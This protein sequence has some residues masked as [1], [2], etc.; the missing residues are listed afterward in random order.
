MY[1][2]T[3]EYVL[4][5]F[6]HQN[7]FSSHLHSQINQKASPKSV[8]NEVCPFLNTESHIWEKGSTVINQA[9]ALSKHVYLF[10]NNCHLANTITCVLNTNLATYLLMKGVCGK[11]CCSCQL[12]WWVSFKIP[13]NCGCKCVICSAFQIVQNSYLHMDSSLSTFNMCCH[14]ITQNIL[15]L[16]FIVHLFKIKVALRC[17]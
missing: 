10:K 13:S 5:I 7:I 17:Q 14:M 4:C 11:G 2:R 8:Q 15:F 1:M 3:I 16:K 9:T 6:W 12:K